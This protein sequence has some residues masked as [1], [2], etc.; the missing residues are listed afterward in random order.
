MTEQIIRVLYGVSLS[1]HNLIASIC[2]GVAVFMFLLAILIPNDNANKSKIL[3]IN[4]NIYFLSIVLS[5]FSGFLFEIEFKRFW[6]VLN[7]SLI[8]FKDNS[9][10][11]FAVISYLLS[12]PILIIIYYFK[13]WKKFK[14]FYAISFLLIFHALL[15]SFWGVFLNTIMQFPLNA[16]INTDGILVL[17]GSISNRF[18][19]GYHLNRQIH[20]LAASTLKAG[21]LVMM[22]FYFSKNLKIEI[23]KIIL[24]ICVATII[25]IAISGHFQIKNIAKYQ[26][27]KFAAME[28]I[29]TKSEKSKWKPLGIYTFLGKEHAF[30]IEGGMFSY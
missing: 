5:A 3:K 17:K 24:N 16:E 22:I 29:T 26:P 25:V 20:I 8:D 30:K 9:A 23:Q 10:H 14:L 21:F 13:L 6:P 7:D 4:L 2:S 18:L 28:N 12:P 27:H 1:A 11:T 19:S 15:F